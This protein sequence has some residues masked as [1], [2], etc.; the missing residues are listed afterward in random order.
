MFHTAIAADQAMIAIVSAIRSVFDATIAAD[1]AMIAIV[2]AVRSV[3]D[4]AI[5]A[6]QAVVTV[7]P[8]IGLVVR[9]GSG[10]IRMPAAIGAVVSVGV[11]CAVRSVVSVRARMIAGVGMI[12]AI[13][14]VVSVVAGT[15]RMITGVVMVVDV[16]V[17]VEDHR[18][19]AASSPVAAPR[20]PTPSEAKATACNNAATTGNHSFYRH[21]GVERDAGADRG[22]SDGGCVRGHHVRNAVNNRRIVLRHIDD[23]WVCRLNHE[24]AG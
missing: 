14:A 9:I 20:A 16:C 17:V 24:R 18:T 15:P 19:T 11:I 13:R 7:V 2:S 21:T 23:L 6:N 12:G 22:N 1:Q 4:A 10:F 3:L 5:A 8:A